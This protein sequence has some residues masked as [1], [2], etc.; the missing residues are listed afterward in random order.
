MTDT[1][2]VAC[3]LDGSVW[4][5]DEAIPPAATSIAH[6]RDAG[7]RVAFVSNNSK[8]PVG[9]GVALDFLALAFAFVLSLLLRADG[10]ACNTCFES[11]R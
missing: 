8:S 11:S 4:R 7:L 1:P 3:D 2:V 5:G 10:R 9:D 6:L